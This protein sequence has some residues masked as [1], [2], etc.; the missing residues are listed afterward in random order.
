MRALRRVSPAL[1]AVALAA[2]LPLSI[3][4]CSADDDGHDAAATGDAG[5]AAADANGG[6]G[7]GGDTDDGGSPRAD[8][9]SPGDGGFGA[10]LTRARVL[11]SGHSLMDNPLPDHVERIAGGRGADLRWNQQNV[12]GSPLRVRTKGSSPGSPGWPGYSTG[13]NRDGSGMNVPAEI[14]AP[15]TLGAGDR[16]DTLVVTERHDLLGCV[17]WENTVGYARHYHDRLVAGN[18]AARTYLYDSWLTMDM[19]NPAPWVDYEKKALYAWECV[20][21][22]VND[23]LAVNGQPRRVATLPAGAAL[24]ALVERLLADAVPGITG[25]PR[26]R[27]AAVFT[28]GVHLTSL[29]SYYV[30]AVTYASV[31]RDS[32]VGAPGPDAANAATVAALQELARDYVRAYYDAPGAGTHTMT[33]CRA[34]IADEVCAGH[35]TLTQSPGEIAN[36]RAWVTNAND[37]SNPFKDEASYTPLPWP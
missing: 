18:A 1:A 12:I 19:D 5:S 9:G 33:E 37:A 21:T 29:G 8:G 25:T 15:Q 31:F 7:D 24:V 4:A 22:K 26:Q 3:G 36:C 23:T 32:P 17:K 34:F 10:P 13:K 27:L 6:A 20:A 28:D 14:L 11:Y 30:A 2:V 35:Y 16:Y